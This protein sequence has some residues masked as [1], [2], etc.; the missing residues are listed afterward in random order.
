[1]SRA[2]RA[3]A[4]VLLAIAAPALAED[5][6]SGE[7]LAGAGSFE[8]QMGQYRPLIDSELFPDLG[9]AGLPWASSFGNSRPF[10]YRIHGGKALVSGYGTLELGGGVGY[11]S[12]T[13]HGL[14]HTG[15]A[16]SPEETGFMMVPLTLDLT[17]RVDPLWERLGIPLVPYGRIAL[18]RDQWWVT[19]A[20]GKSSMS[21]AT[22][23][24]GWAGGLALVLD[25]IDPTLAREL[26]RDSGIK[27]TMLV[28]EVGQNK[29]DDFGSKT[30]WDLS[31]DKLAVS[32][33]FLFAF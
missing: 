27:H 30:S 18:L 32:F 31:S 24:W 4:L 21:G 7:R 5:R 3:A 23:G 9:T 19:G 25:F 15:G 33:G 29:V 1:M 14:F 26:D 10:L 17:Y 11:Y 2:I 22:N 20:G 6:A 13:G 28:V 16:V 12:V 8:F